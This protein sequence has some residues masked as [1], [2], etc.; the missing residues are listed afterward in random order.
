MGLEPSGVELRFG[1]DQ[2]SS[3]RAYRTAGYRKYRPK[4]RAACG[5]WA[6]NPEGFGFLSEKQR[7]HAVRGSSPLRRESGL[8]TPRLY[9]C[10]TAP[11]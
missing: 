5:T 6:G 1:T 2:K 11:S 10:A 7:T 3:W 9:G 8:A 4:V